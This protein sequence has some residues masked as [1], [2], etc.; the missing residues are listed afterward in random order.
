MPTAR[1]APLAAAKTAMR[2]EMRRKRAYLTP[3]TPYLT[4]RI[5]GDCIG[6]FWPIGSE[7][8]I[9]PLLSALDRPV[10]LPVVRGRGRALAFG[11]WR[12]GDPLRP[13]PFGT[14]EPTGPEARPDT[15]LVPLLA[16]DA[17][18][19]R[20]GYGGGHYDRTLSR[21][22]VCAIGVAYAAQR[23]AAVPVGPGD[24]RLDAVLTEM[25]I[26]RFGRS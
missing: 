26:H 4:A 11:R 19:N 23:V 22:D 10:V 20:L 14:M 25:G 7:I 9:R 1:A 15:L 3:R 13:G 24:R 18:G 21:M 6:A 17:C 16:F 8:D 5:P 2:R 12:P